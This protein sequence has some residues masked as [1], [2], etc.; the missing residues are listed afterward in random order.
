MKILIVEND[1][2]TAQRIQADLESAG[3]VVTGN[4]LCLADAMQG[5]Q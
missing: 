1:V 5:I 3:H 4:V 2:F